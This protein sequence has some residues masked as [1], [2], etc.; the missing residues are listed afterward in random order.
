MNDEIYILD[1]KYI[2]IIL[3][4]TTEMFTVVLLSDEGYDSDGFEEFLIYFKNTW[5]NIHSNSENYKLYINLDTVKNN[6]LPLHAYVDLLNC[7]NEI[8]DILKTKC[9]CICIF[10][11]NCKPWQDAYN[12]ITKLWN[13]KGQR[14]ILFTD[15]ADEKNLFLQSNKLITKNFLS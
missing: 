3:N 2:K 7:I 14:P 9:H 12:F 10:T 6:D 4:K 13:P 11:H 15:D 8:D 1:R 5:K